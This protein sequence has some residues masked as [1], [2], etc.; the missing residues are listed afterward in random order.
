MYLDYHAAT[1]MKTEIPTN[2][3]G[4]KEGEAKRVECVLGDMM[5]EEFTSF[6]KSQTRVEF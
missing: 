1:Y 6:G 4:R 5:L 2:K 3:Q